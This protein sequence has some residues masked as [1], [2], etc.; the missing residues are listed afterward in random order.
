MKSKLQQM[1]IKI[2]EENY[3]YLSRKSLETGASRSEIIRR[4]LAEADKTES[5]RK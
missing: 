1:H 2:T 5:K 3:D 4:L